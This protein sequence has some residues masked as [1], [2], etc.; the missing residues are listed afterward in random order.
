MGL[1]NNPFGHVKVLGSAF[2]A[3]LFA[4]VLSSGCSRSSEVPV[5]DFSQTISMEKPGPALKEYPTLKVAVGAMIS[6]K[7]T[8]IHYRQLLAYLGRK[9]GRETEFIQRK[10]YKEINEL[11]GTGQVDIAFICSGPYAMGKE[12]YGFEL[13]AVPQ[14]QGSTVYQSYLIV[15]DEAFRRLE[16][17]KGRTFAFTDPES[18]TGRL[19]PAYWLAEIGE[20]PDQYFGKTIYTYSHDNSIL[21]VSRGLVDGAAV[22]SLIWEFYRATNPS[23]TASTRVIR[24]SEPYPVPPVV[25]SGAFA[26]DHI[27]QTRQALFAMDHEPEGRQIL[28]HLKIDRFILPPADWSE[29]I[30]RIKRMLAY[31]EGKN[32]GS[33]KP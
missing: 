18:N 10:T 26:R 14:T 11:L 2:Y 1:T 32:H 16:D 23:V 12:R 24:K 25:A 29:N 13:L 9:I 3:I 22:D 8:F 31:V 5:I 19:V 6:P 21:A 28:E 30:P 15:K 27:K 4:F 33:E 20:R 7:E 17:L